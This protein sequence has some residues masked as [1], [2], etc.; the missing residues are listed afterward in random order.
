MNIY[1]VTK[2]GRT[3]TDAGLMH[4]S[5]TILNRKLATADEIPEFIQGAILNNTEYFIKELSEHNDAII[6]LSTS[7]NISYITGEN[8]F[9]NLITTLN[10]NKDKTTLIKNIDD[11]TAQGDINLRN[12]SFSIFSYKSIL[13]SK[14]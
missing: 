9:K 14:K 13:D 10:E 8:T 5:S 6:A 3:Y 11:D 2:E 1:I 12:V 7:D 4:I